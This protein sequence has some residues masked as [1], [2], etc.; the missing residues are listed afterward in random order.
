ML[1]NSEGAFHFPSRS[2][3]SKHLRSS[4][5]KDGN[6]RKHT[7]LCLENIISVFWLHEPAVIENAQAQT[8]RGGVKVQANI[9]HPEPA[10]GAQSWSTA[11]LESLR[12]HFCLENDIGT[13]FGMDVVVEG[14]PLA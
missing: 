3:S 8:V 9:L 11:S 7:V 1:S 6:R 12:L 4:H 14:L 2:G 5:F 13:R 10:A